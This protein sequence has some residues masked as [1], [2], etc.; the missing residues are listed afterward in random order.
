MPGVVSF[1][2]LSTQVVGEERARFD[3]ERS[4]LEKELRKVL[5]RRLRFL[6]AAPST[7]RARPRTRHA[8]DA[9]LLD[10]A[11]IATR[12]PP[13]GEEGLQGFCWTTL[14][15][16][17]SNQGREDRNPSGQAGREAHPQR[18]TAISKTNV[19]LTNEAVR[20]YG[21]RGPRGET[22]IPQGAR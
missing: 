5:L 19:P 9:G 21:P 4:R 18:I 2:I 3:K 14:N 10:G 8:L 1:L 7:R 11:T 22:E 20:Q 16:E 13:A 17:R 12:A 6:T 15:I